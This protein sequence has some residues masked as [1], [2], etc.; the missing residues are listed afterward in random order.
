MHTPPADCAA[1]KQRF[2]GSPPLDLARG[3]SDWLVDSRVCLCGL[4]SLKSDETSAM[5]YCN[6][7][8]GTS[9][10]LLL[11]CVFFGGWKQEGKGDNGIFVL[12]GVSLFGDMQILF[13]C[14]PNA[15]INTFLV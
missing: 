3:Q 12:I 10:L 5:G 9:S 7:F 14:L 4:G 11:L 13:N 8:G 6:Q 15:R 2:V 1:D